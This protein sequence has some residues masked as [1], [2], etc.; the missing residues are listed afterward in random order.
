MNKKKAYKHI[1]YMASIVAI[2][3]FALTV[4][5]AEKE[6]SGIIQ[7]NSNIQEIEGLSNK[8][9]GWGIKRNDNHEQPD[10]GSKNREIL[11]KYNGY[12]LGNKDSKKVY[13]TF[14]EGY[15][16][17]Y[18]EKILAVLKEND[19]KATFFITAHYVNT[20]PELVQKMIDEGH[21]IGNHTVN[22]KSM[23]DL[24]NNTIKKEVM[25]LHTAIYE[26]YKYEMKYIRPP[27]GEY[28][29]RTVA[30]TNTLGYK[31]VMWSFAYDDWDENKQGRESYAKEKI[32]NNVHNGAII[33][34]HGN[35][36]DN[37]NVL[38]ECIKE[39]KKMGYEF[40]SL[41]EFER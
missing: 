24:D 38:D 27:K 36:K 15:E 28:S 16:A 18:T 13:L 17:G 40:K 39:I 37:T 20:K 14:D 22:H 41:D 26:K 1:I 21:I 11:D 2:L 35:S 19:V 34:L 9:I 29:Q 30:F 25:D 33:L 10:V 7:T 3:L 6:K 5:K 12:C 32:L 4:T 23:P 8:K 31:T